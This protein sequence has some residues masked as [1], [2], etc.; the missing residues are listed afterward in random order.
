[1]R[2]GA[3]VPVLRMFDVDAMLEF[4]CGYLGFTKDWEHRFEPGFPLYVQVSRSEAVIHLSEHYGDGSPNTVLWIPVD[5][6][7]GFNA[8]LLAKHHGYSRPG[9]EPDGPGG[10]TM[11]VIDPSGNHLRFAQPE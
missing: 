1:V 7:A 9:I 2:I 10:P 11:T 8:E 4:Y 6:V 5:D 3:P